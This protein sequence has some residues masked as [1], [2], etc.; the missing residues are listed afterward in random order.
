MRKLTENQSNVLSCLEDEFL[1]LKD[2]CVK[3]VV[4]MGKRGF[5]P[6]GSVWSNEVS[7]CLN[8][9]IKR[10]LVDYKWK[11]FYKKKV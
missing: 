4:I 5:N 9:L 6:N 7:R 11:G 2:I 3:Y 8:S 1:Q 10:Q